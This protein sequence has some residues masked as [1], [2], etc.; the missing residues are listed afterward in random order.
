MNQFVRTVMHGLAAAPSP[1]QVKRCAATRPGWIGPIGESIGAVA[2]A[3]SCFDDLL[4]VERDAERV[5][6]HVDR[7]QEAARPCTATIGLCAASSGVLPNSIMSPMTLR[8]VVACGM[9]ENSSA[10][11]C[12]TL[13]ESAGDHQREAL[14]DAARVD[15]GA[16]QRHAALLTRGLERRRRPRAFG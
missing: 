14:G 5:G 13:R 16:V 7:L 15:A 10:R 4:V 3:T 6:H 8:R 9:S 12:V 1:R 11:T 2:T